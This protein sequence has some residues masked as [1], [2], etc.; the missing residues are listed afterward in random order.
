MNFMIK[1]ALVGLVAAI[2]IIVTTML[3]GLYLIAQLIAASA[4]LVIGF[5]MGRESARGELAVLIREMRN[6]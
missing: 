2:L 5:V 4:M 6:V 1:I 3:F